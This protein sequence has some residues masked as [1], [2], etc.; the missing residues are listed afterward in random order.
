MANI[1]DILESVYPSNGS[2]GVI[3]TDT[4]RITFD[5]AM[6]EECLKEAIVVEGPDSDEIIYNSYLPA[7]LNPGAEDRLLETP[8]Y[9]GLVP[10]TLTFERLDPV[11]GLPVSI[12]DTTGNGALYKTRVT[13]KADQPFAPDTTYR[14]HI[15]GDE[16]LSD[17]EEFGAKN[18]SVY[19]GVAGVSNT[20]TGSPVVAG[21]YTGGLTT[22]T[23]NIKITASGILGKA[24]FEW[25]LDSVPFDLRGPA[26][27][28][29][30]TLNLIK[31]TTVRFEEGLYE[32][33]DEWSFVLRRPEFFQGH[34]TFE[35]TTGGGTIVP[36]ADTTA[37]SPTGTPI[38]PELVLAGTFAVQKTTP[39][40]MDVNLKPEQ[41]DR[42]V[43]EFTDTIDPASVTQETV[44]VTA[45]P[46]IDHP[47]LHIQSPDGPIAKILTVSGNKLFIDI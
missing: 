44:L 33:G 46:V 24:E 27:T 17:D 47:N 25:W 28:H 13:F 29:V 30:N 38:P 2:V 35:F 16:D 10:G 19:D 22:D 32:V 12:V 14:V 3:L 1:G 42:I 15:I 39:G 8:G 23:V 37:T 36:V 43:I 9:D 6:D 21:T 41:Y 40:D 20:S 45:E 31:G 11:T 4:I 5:R 26:L 18:R 7:E 34:Q